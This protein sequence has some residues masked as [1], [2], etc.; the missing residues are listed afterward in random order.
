MNLPATGPSRSLVFRTDMMG[1]ALN[2]MALDDLSLEEGTCDQKPEPG[3]LHQCHFETEDVCGY[4][5]DDMSGD[6]NTNL[7]K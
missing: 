6:G 7:F 5:T 4:I 2:N 1:Q 3:I